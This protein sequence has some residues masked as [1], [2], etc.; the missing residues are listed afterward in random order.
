MGLV[1]AQ[2]EN[3]TWVLLSTDSPPVRGAKGVRCELGSSR[4]WRPRL[5]DP[6]LLK[7]A[8]SV[9]EGAWAGARGWVVLARYSR[10]HLDAWLGLWNQSPWDWLNSLSLWSCPGWEAQ[11]RCGHTQCPPTV[12]LYIGVYPSGREGSLPPSF[13]WGTSML[14]WAMTVR[15][16]R[17]WLGVTALPIWIRVLFCGWT[18]VLVMDCT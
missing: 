6:W 7:L 10:T 14:T 11:S 13:C 18:S 12:C 16:R 5:S 15:P 4:R 8:L 2:P 17:V 3:M 1:W 9:G